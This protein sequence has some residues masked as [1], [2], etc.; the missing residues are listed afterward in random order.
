MRRVNWAGV[1][2][3]TTALLILIAILLVVFVVNPTTQENQS[4][5]REQQRTI[6]EQQTTLHAVICAQAQSTANVYRFRSLTPSG[7]VEGIRHFLTRM[8]AQEQTLKL[9]RGLGCKSSPG[10]PPFEVQIRRA[11][12]EIR[13]ILERFSPKMQRPVSERTSREQILPGPYGGEGILSEP[14]FPGSPPNPAP[15][16]PTE[17]GAADLDDGSATGPS[18]PRTPKSPSPTPPP[19]ASPAAPPPLPPPASPPTPAV[20]PPAPPKASQVVDLL[21]EAAPPLCTVIREIHELC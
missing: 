13:R 2:A 17:P 15:S 19:P 11:L 6:R 1:G 20:T 18:S 14:L 16:P 8:Q 4:G 3:V 7:D 12:F 5:L 10:F 9:S 21:S